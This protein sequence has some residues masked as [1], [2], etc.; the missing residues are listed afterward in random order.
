MLDM[1]SIFLNLLRFDLWPKIWSI[2]E[3]VPCALEKKVYS[4]AFGWN[5]LK[6]SMRSMSCNVSYQTCVSLLIFCFDDLSIGVN[7]VLKSPTIIVLLSISPFVSVNVSLMYWGAPSYV[8]CIDIYNCYVFLL[9]WSLD[10]YL[11]SFL[12]SWNILYFKV[13]FVWYENCYSSF[14][15]LPI[16]MEYIF[17]FSHFQ[18]I[19]VLRSEVCFL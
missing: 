5:V 18:S 15:L 10:H 2:L 19:C 16:C 3:N 1:I 12:I 14:L 8:G 13:Y 7:G 9:Y 17:P 11:V 6:I 4:S